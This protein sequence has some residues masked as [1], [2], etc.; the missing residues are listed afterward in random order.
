M[1]D[2]VPPVFDLRPSF[3]MAHDTGVVVQYQCKEK[4]CREVH[5]GT[6]L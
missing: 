5:Y 6:F 3:V 2:D 4:M 1:R